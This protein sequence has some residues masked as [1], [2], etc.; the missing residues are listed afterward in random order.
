MIQSIGASFLNI[1]ILN[2][3]PASLFWSGLPLAIVLYYLPVVLLAWYLI[4]PSASRVGGVLDQVSRRPFVLALCLLIL[5]QASHLLMFWLLNYSIYIHQSGIHFSGYITGS[6]P[7]WREF[8]RW[9]P[10]GLINAGFVFVLAR[11]RLLRIA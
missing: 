10:G 11:K 3:V 4:R 7:P 8:L 9:L 6:I 1:I 2:K 5:G